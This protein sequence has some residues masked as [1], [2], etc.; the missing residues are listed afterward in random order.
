[1][2]RD[3][4]LPLAELTKGAELEA[5]VAQVW[6]WEG[7]FT[8]FGVNLQHHYSPETLQVTDL[9]LL[10]YDFSPTLVRSKVIGEVKSGSRDKPLDRSIWLGGLLQLVKADAGEVTT[11]LV[12]TLKVRD[13]ARTLRITAQSIE[14]LERREKAIGIIELGELGSQGKQAV[15][16]LDQVRTLCS[17]DPDLER[18]FW[19]LRSEVWFLDPISSCKRI[20]GLLKQLGLRWTP[21]VDA[22]DDRCLRWLYAESIVVFV[23]NVVT[24]SGYAL[25][26]D[27]IN[28]TRLLTERLSEGTIPIGEMRRLGIKIDKYIAGILAAA[29]APAAIKVDAMGALEPRAPEYTETFIELARRLRAVSLEARRAPRQLDLLLHER[30]SNRREPAAIG[31]QRIGLNSGGEGARLRRVIA[32]FLRSQAGLPDEIAEA[33]I[34]DVV[35]APTTKT[36]LLFDTDHAAPVQGSLLEV[37]D[38]S[39]PPDHGHG[40]Q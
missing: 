5:R 28:F 16:T 38:S 20:I 31:A 39:S 36:P 22:G 2:Q 33:I 35:G 34:I 9:D 10:A 24:V 18:A 17:E 15:G 4:T 19:F 1:V 30:L 26:L 11:R 40:D 21:G 29:N 14:D 6:F 12:P 32:A 27:E 13:L 23:L 37:P 25:T 7:Y 3:K 8:R